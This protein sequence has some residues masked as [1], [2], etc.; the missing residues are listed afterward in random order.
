MGRHL[1]WNAR[2]TTTRSVFVVFADREECQALSYTGPYIIGDTSTYQF[3][4][5]YE[6]KIFS[7]YADSA[8]LNG[9]IF[10]DGSPATMN[11]DIAPIGD[12]HMLSLIATGNVNTCTF[13]QDRNNHYGGQRL[14]EAIICTNAQSLA[15]V[16]NI[17]DYFNVKWFGKTVTNAAAYTLGNLTVAEDATL[18]IGLC[19]NAGVSTAVSLSGAAR[20]KREHWQLNI[21]PRRNAMSARDGRRSLSL[22]SGAAWTW[23]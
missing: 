12:F 13:S 1:V 4:R 20:S 18:D 15:N 11:T 2:C 9:L 22:A 16:T 8:L 5:G 7:I 23:T 6:P 21:S 10:L 14:A 17:T 19:L 3:S